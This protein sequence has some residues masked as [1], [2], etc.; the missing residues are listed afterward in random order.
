MDFDL[1]NGE[2]KISVIY[3]ETGHSVWPHSVTECEGMLSCWKMKLA[4]PSSCVKA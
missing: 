1:L 2:A 4:C 3:P